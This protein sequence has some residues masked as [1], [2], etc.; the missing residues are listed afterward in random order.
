MRRRSVAAVS[1]AFIFFINALGATA[2][3]LRL[4]STGA[5]AALLQRLADDHS[6]LNP[7]HMVEIT[8]GLGSGGAIAAVA[9]GAIDLA[10]SSRNINEKEQQLGVIS[11]PLF[12]TPYIF[13]SSSSAP[14]SLSVDE[15]L[16]YYAGTIRTYPNGETVRLILRP[17]N[18][19]NT[20]Y[21][22][23]AIPGMAAAQG[24][25]R[26]RHDIPVA[27]T[28][29]DNM[30]HM[31]MIAGAFSGMSLSQLSMEPNTL[32]RVRL[33]NVEGSLET[34]KS[35]AYPFKIMMY[36]ITTKSPGPA[37]QAF[38]AFLMSPDGRRTIGKA[39]G[40]LVEP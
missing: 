29:Q 18:D 12:E 11:T 31:K 19:A 23:G 17:R 6:A 28:D 38:K 24:Q 39:G 20:V 2:E 27:G 26:L 9:A 30:Q 5:V 15:I 1:A 10:I 35:G 33:N 37:A 7:Q 36:V 22:L 13:V 4:G 14:L 3:P 40:Q 21:V 16:G 8:P 32:Q 25:A 34:I